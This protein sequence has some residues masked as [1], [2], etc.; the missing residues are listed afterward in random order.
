MKPA[1]LEQR[2]ESRHALSP[3]SHSV[4]EGTL[5]RNR[6]CLHF[7]CHADHQ[8]RPLLLSQAL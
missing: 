1:R 3:P 4:W 2:K 5:T 6:R 8:R 7:F